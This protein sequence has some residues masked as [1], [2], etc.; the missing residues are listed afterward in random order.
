[1]YASSVH[2]FALLIALGYYFYDYLNNKKNNF[3]WVLGGISALLLYI[4]NT[5]HHPIWPY[6]EYISAVTWGFQNFPY[7]FYT[8]VFAL[9]L[10]YIYKKISYPFIKTMVIIIGKSSFHI[11][12]AQI[13]VFFIQKLYKIEMNMLYAFLTF[14][15]SLLLGIVWHKLEDLVLKW[16]ILNVE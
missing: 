2:R 1:M 13:F 3:I 4:Y 14:F 12:L 11:Y 7:A 6:S 9:L 10:V 16:C 15:L 5:T 8:V